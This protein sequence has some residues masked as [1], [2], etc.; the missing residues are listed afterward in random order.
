MTTGVV[1]FPQ[2]VL[3]IAQKGKTLDL[4]IFCVVYDILKIQR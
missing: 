1:S 2:V 4:C 3:A